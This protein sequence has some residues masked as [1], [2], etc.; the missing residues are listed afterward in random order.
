MIQSRRVDLSSYIEKVE[1]STK[2]EP[3]EL[4]QRQAEDYLSFIKVLSEEVNI[5]DKAFYVIIGHTAKGAIEKE[6]LVDKILKRKTTELTNFSAEAF[7]A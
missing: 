7:A 3:N 6:T 5:M 2:A 1:N 4:L